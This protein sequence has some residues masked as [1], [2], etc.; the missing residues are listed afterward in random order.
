MYPGLAPQPSSKGTRSHKAND[1]SNVKK[2]AGHKILTGWRKGAEG[3][4]ACPHLI[5]KCFFPLS[6]SNS[7]SGNCMRSLKHKTHTRTH[8]CIC[9]CIHA[10]RVL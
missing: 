8:K 4:V 10:Y 7:F 3:F 2:H 1:N 9:I 6:S 5:T